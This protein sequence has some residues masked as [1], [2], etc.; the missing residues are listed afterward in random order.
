MNLD[1]AGVVRIQ[2]L[3][4][5]AIGSWFFPKKKSLHFMMTGLLAG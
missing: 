1:S 3:G 5:A 4:M 2:T